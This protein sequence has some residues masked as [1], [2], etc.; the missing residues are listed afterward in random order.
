MSWKRLLVE[1]S[2]LTN[3]KFFIS[4]HFIHPNE[5]RMI[6]KPPKSISVD[7][8][9]SRMTKTTMDEAQWTRTRCSPFFKNVQAAGDTRMNHF[10]EFNHMI[11]IEI[12]VDTVILP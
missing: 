2:K 9:R 6:I 3:N 12:V 11:H 1:S 10:Y 5:N 4:E 8:S 7:G